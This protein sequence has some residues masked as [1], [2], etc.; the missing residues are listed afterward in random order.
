MESVTNAFVNRLG[1]LPSHQSVGKNGTFWLPPESQN[2]F[3][4]KLKNLIKNP[5]TSDNPAKPA[6]SKPS[7][8]PS[9][10]GSLVKSSSLPETSPKSNV[11]GQNRGVTVASTMNTSHPSGNTNAVNLSRS[12]H[13]PLHPVSPRNGDTSVLNN[14]STNRV[15]DKKGDA[16]EGSLRD[17]ENHQQV[18]EN[19]EEERQ[20]KNGRH[21][22]KNAH[23]A[24]IMSLFENIDTFVTQVITRAKSDNCFNQRSL[25][26]LE[27]IAREVA[28][29]LAYLDKNDR[30][31]VRM[32]IDLPNGSPLSIR[33]E[34]N[35]SNLSLSFISDDSE[36]VEV[37]KYIRDLLTGSKDNSL[38][39]P[40]TINL[41][42]SY[43]EMDSHFKQAA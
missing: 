42:K 3:S 20:Q 38:D 32:A 11:N 5:K 33:I 21:G 31:V 24:S 35:S 29:K 39:S 26:T 1:N 34:Q 17:K 7:N 15:L 2:N 23:L 9:N 18:G 10:Q 19:V 8:A 37:L 13:P 28:A 22:T 41:F 27:Y 40:I 25:K 4:S 14:I 36:S 12:I 16:I 6:Q 43:N 30:K